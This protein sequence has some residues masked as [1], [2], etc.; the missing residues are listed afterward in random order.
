[1]G[2]DFA[3]EIKTQM[4]IRA[5]VSLRLPRGNQYLTVKI[6]DRGLPWVRQAKIPG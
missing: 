3:T 4:D 2:L 6:S 1:M 5:E